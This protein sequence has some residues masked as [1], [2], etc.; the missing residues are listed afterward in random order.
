MSPV[1]PTLAGRFF[2]QVPQLLKQRWTD[3]GLASWFRSPSRFLSPLRA[4]RGRCPEDGIPTAILQLDQ[5]HALG[6][7][8]DVHYR[9]EGLG[10]WQPPGA[11]AH[12]LAVDDDMLIFLSR[13]GRDL[14]VALQAP[15]GVRP[16]L[17]GK[18]RTPL[19]SQ[20]LL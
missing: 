19:S 11:G 6:G 12:V 14:G 5:A 18:P 9:V 16:R 8:E 17:E 4:R 7:G 13:E 3:Q 2:T 10:G 20:A 15:P 1:S